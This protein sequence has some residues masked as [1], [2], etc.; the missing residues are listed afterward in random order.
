M[1]YFLSITVICLFELRWI[2]G[3]GKKESSLKI[4]QDDWILYKQIQEKSEM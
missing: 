4:A 1:Y 2:F 3:N